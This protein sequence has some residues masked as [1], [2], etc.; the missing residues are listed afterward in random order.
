MRKRIAT[1]LVLA[2]VA[3]MTISQVVMAMHVQAKSI[4]H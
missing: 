3:A 1:A 4:L 2:S